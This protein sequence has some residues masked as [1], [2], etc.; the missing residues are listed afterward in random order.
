MEETNHRATQE[1][2]GIP[3]IQIKK[4]GLSS[5]FF[6]I[7]FLNDRVLQDHEHDHDLSLPD[8]LRELRGCFL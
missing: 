8:S 6:S 4:T 2:Y 7:M 3:I 1:K 5:G